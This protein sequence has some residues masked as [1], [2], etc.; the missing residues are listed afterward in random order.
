MHKKFLHVGR[1]FLCIFYNCIS[2]KLNKITNLSI[3]NRFYSR[4]GTGIALYN[5]RRE[6]S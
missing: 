6:R 5:G 2:L 3:T 1:N 4:I